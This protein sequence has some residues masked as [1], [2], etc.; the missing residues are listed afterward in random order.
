MNRS[1]RSL[2]T[3]VTTTLT[4]AALAALGM[5]QVPGTAS[6]NGDPAAGARQ[7]APAHPATNNQERPT[8][9]NGSHGQA[10]TELQQRLAVHGHALTADGDFG[11]RT[12]TAVK[13]FQKRHG[14]WADGIVGPRTWNALLTPPSTK[15]TAPR[16]ATYTLKFTKNWNDPQN[17]RLALLQD[18]KPVV[19]YRAGSGKDFSR[20]ECAGGTGWLPSGEYE[21]ARHMTDRGAD[22]MPW[23]EPAVQ[24]YVIE[25]ADK[26][27]KPV[28]GQKAVNRTDLF[29][30]SEMKSD[31]TQGFSIFEDDSLRRWEG[32][33]DY[34]SSGCVKLHPDHIK[35]LFRHL[36]RVGWPEDLTL[37]VG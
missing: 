1:P 25:L 10:V 27:C 37:E 24:G 18:G 6:A 36:D 7:A 8:L 2:W 32:D 23:N 31:G 17:S 30:H 13:A 14:L 26:V 35:D 22:A 4:V 15:P 3:A 20:N 5:T 21:I 33:G 19:S 11:P 29:I 16:P 9:R 28:S 34:K 12:K